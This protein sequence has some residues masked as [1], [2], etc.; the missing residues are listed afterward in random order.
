[1]QKDNSNEG[2]HRTIV[3]QKSRMEDRDARTV[4]KHIGKIE[5]QKTQGEYSMEKTC[6]KRILMKARIEK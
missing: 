5:P 2:K 3:T 4:F 6:R 1:M